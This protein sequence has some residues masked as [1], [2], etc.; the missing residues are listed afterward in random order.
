MRLSV[1]SNRLLWIFIILMDVLMGFRGSK[2]SPR[3]GRTNS[4]GRSLP[5]NMLPICYLLC[6]S[7]FA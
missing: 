7:G 1:A 3:E 6:I 5:E 4:S 2:S